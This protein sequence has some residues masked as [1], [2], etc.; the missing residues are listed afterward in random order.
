MLDELKI[1]QVVINLLSNAIKF[2]PNDGD[3]IISATLEPQLLT[4]DIK[5]SG[6]GIPDI[7]KKAIFERFF[8]VHNEN[9]NKDPG[10][11]LG[12]AISKH[13]IEMHGG[14]IEIRNESDGAR[15]TC[16]IPVDCS[17]HGA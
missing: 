5:D 3:I 7:H 16:C 15:F 1:K 8:Q 9:S 2:T 17:I 13:F 11:G 4:I 14:T 10:S 6:P 12:L